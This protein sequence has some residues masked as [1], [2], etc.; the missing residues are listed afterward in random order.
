[1]HDV[2]AVH[3][4]RS[5]GRQLKQMGILM[6][7]A[8][9]VGRKAIPAIASLIVFSA[10]ITSNPAHADEATIKNNPA[11]K[12]AIGPG[13]VDM[14]TG[15]YTYSQTDLSIGPDNG[16]LTLTRSTPV[17]VDGHANPFGNFS[18]NWDIMLV[19]RRV[20][21]DHPDLSTGP[22]YRMTLH[23]GGR[24]FVFESYGNSTGFIY[25]SDGAL[26]RLTYSGGQRDSST[27]IYALQSPDGTTYEFRPMGSNDCTTSKRCAYVSKVTQPDGTVYTLGYEYNSGAANNRARLTRITSSR[28]YVLMLE[29]SGNRVNKACALNAAT[30]QP[31]AGVTCPG[32]ALA[33]ATYSYN[34]DGRLTAVAGADGQL[35]QFTYSPIAGEPA[36]S[37]NM[38][39]IKPGYSTPW[40][41]NT[42]RTE[43]DEE[44]VP[45][46]VT[47]RQQFA[48]G[49]SYTY[50]FDRTPVTINK[51]IT[52]I[53]GGRVVDGL[54]NQQTYQ[55]AF[56]ILPGSRQRICRTL[57]CP[58]P[59]PDDEFR[60]TYQQTTGPVLIVDELGRET[61]LDYC[62]PSVSSGL[63]AQEIDRCAI[64]KDYSLVFA[65]G[66]TGPMGNVGPPIANV[67]VNHD[68]FGN[69]VKSTLYP[70][71]GSS[72][73]PIET[74]AAFAT[75]NLLT[76]TK[77]LWRKDANGN[78]TDWTY[79]PNHGG[80]LSE[81]GSAVNGVRPQKRYSYAQR[82]AWLSNGSGGYVQA[83]T[84]IWLLV[85]ES[86][87]R[88]SAWTGSACA[89]GASDEVVTTYDYG[90]NSGP[91]NLLLRGT[92]VTADGVTRRTCFGY[93]A[94]GRKIS[95]TTPNANLTVC[96]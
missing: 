12:Y 62:D 24:S 68:G 57:P 82:Y 41:T 91:N 45:H 7:Q 4:I 37:F 44:G 33:T 39:F 25:K 52:S 32:S 88:T 34:G 22:D 43:V 89:A 71:A 59:M 92:T 9:S 77:P 76:Q 55:Y 1:M 60:F 49:R 14:R 85:S 78:Q 74:T 73:A 8:L 47:E 30:A 96:P 10:M 70:K 6:K 13:G 35:H 93:D 40:L 54:G 63:P 3:S 69:V 5:S 42:I 15:Q 26:A 84:P 20:D 38:A 87:C 61:K 2:P 95:E 17:Y 83:N 48:D 58:P 51:P 67:R 11:E 31:P 79:D 53:V 19:E 36:S 81:T 90:P 56:P 80:V 46:E 75:A 29:G 23:I 18:N 94:F 86:S 65:E 72:L 66:G 28:G 21:I 27:V 50:Y 16:G 64:I